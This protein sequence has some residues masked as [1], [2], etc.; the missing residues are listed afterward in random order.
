MNG[1]RPFEISGPVRIGKAVEAYEA[2]QQKNSRE[3]E[4]KDSYSL[5]CDFTHPNA[6]SLLRY[7]AWEEEGMVIRFIDLDR[8]P[9]QESFLPFVN[10]CL[11]DL[12]VFLYE[13]LGVAQETIVQPKIRLVLD[14]LAR[15]APPRLTSSIP[16]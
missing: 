5:L 1:L 7:Q 13:L 14:E 11:I 2:Y 16:A 4:A 8:D 9:T 12:L 10:C 3:R 15:L 6:A